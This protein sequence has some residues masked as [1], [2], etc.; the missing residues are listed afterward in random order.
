MS[1]PKCKIILRELDNRG[2]VKSEWALGYTHPVGEE[3]CDETVTFHDDIEARVKVFK[4][5]EPLTTYA[6]EGEYA[7][8]G[9][10]VRSKG[11]SLALT[12]FKFENDECASS[13]YGTV[14]CDRLHQVIKK[15]QNFLTATRDGISWRHPVAKALKE[16]VE[17]V[18]APIVE[19]ERREKNAR[20]NTD[21]SRELRN[22]L[23]DA[24]DELNKLAGKVLGELDEVVDPGEDVL[25]P[26]VPPSGFGFVPDF[27]RIQSGGSA[28][29]LLRANL[30]DRLSAGARITISSDTAQVRVLTNEVMLEA[31][32]DH[33]D[34]G[35]ARVR[36][37]GRQIGASGKLRAEVEGEIAEAT[38]VVSAKPEIPPVP[39][40]RK[41][42]G[43]KGLFRD[44]KF[45]FKP[46][47][48]QRVQFTE[49]G[50]IEINTGAPSVRP[51]IS[52]DSGEGS[53]TPQGSILLA[54]LVA[55][56]CCSET[57]RIGVTQGTLLSFG[58]SEGDSIRSHYLKLQNQFTHLIHRLFVRGDLMREAEQENE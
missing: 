40:E 41:K 18:L 20:R 11:L 13:L 2:G 33:T 25:R 32:E 48:G 52:R 5:K 26:F 4:A 29:L 7:D 42:R 37:E 12:L 58:G 22:R 16:A 44:V 38:V 46:E 57:A 54:E 8:A 19:K 56:A 55:E 24:L 53:E 35:E 39:H 6:E 28:S 34:I 43:K 27:A 17:K 10:I 3:V 31:R 50:I 9:L 14:R 21:V 23:D 15:D 30:G 49:D 51:Y 47:Q 45:P 1:D 36:V